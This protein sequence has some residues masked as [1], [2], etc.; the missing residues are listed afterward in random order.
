MNEPQPNQEERIVSALTHSSIILFGMGAIVAVVVWATQKER[1]RYV[2]FQALQSLVYQ[3]AG[4]LA[5]G[6]SMCCWLALYFASFIPL[7][8][9]AEQG[10]NDP[11]LF[12][13]GAMALMLV[14]FAVMGLWILGGLWAAVRTLQG[15]DFSYL[16][17]GNQLKRWLAA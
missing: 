4:F 15:R 14:P 7:M 2:A 10:S 6:V 3:M 8:A 12:F 1:S 5:F 17:I 9:A 16:V 13:I 11:P